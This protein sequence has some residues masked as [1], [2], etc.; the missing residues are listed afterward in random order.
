MVKNFSLIIL[1]IF[2]ACAGPKGDPITIQ[3]LDTPEAFTE[4]LNTKNDS[5]QLVLLLSPT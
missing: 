3:N 2:M 1:F 5:P 4:I